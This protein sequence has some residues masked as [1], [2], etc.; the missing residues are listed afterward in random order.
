MPAQG[1]T[2]TIHG[3]AHTVTGSCLEFSH[4][5]RTMLVDCGLFQG[6]RSLEALNAVTE[7]LGVTLVDEG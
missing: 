3:A 5:G 6:S 4:G 2:L 7:P 1:P